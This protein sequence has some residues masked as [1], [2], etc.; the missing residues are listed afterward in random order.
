AVVGRG[1]VES[2]EVLHGGR[3]S[4]FAR[5]LAGLVLPG[6]RRLLGGGFVVRARRGGDNDDD[7][8]D[9]DPQHGREGTGQWS[10]TTLH[11]W[12]S[13]K[14]LQ[15]CPTSS[16]GSGWSS[17]CGTTCRRCG[18]RASRRTTPTS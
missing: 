10:R 2:E 6:A 11:P 12:P 16:C 1:R 18:S 14:R 8:D 13:P 7:G 5:D 9:D 17:G 15:P 3:E 4:R